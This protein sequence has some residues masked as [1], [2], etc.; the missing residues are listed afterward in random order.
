MQGCPGKNDFQGTAEI[1]RADPR[2]AKDISVFQVMKKGG[3]EAGDTVFRKAGLVC[4]AELGSLAGTEE[5]EIVEARG[6]KSLL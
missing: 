6:R 5:R 4:G 1:Y 3:I 2:E